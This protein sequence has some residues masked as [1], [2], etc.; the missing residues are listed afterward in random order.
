MVLDLQTRMQFLRSLS[1]SWGDVCGG[2]SVS[3]APLTVCWLA[4][5]RRT[6]VYEIHNCMHE[7][8]VCRPSML[9]LEA[10]AAMACPTTPPQPKMAW[11]PQ[12]CT[13]P[14]SGEDCFEGSETC[15]R[16]CLLRSHLFGL[17]RLGRGGVHARSDTWSIDV[18][19]CHFG[20]RER[21][22]SD[23]FNFRF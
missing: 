7:S 10:F 12:P 14:F 18:S 9:E 19:R 4:C 11:V 20:S 13:P 15:W 22:S 23:H 6:I 2:F 3:T 21:I 5:L 17:V 16:W 8:T 1:C